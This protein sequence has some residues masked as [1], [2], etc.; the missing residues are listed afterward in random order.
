[1]KICLIIDD[2]LPHS[3][4]VGAKMMHELGVQFVK[5]GHSV[6]VITPDDT[7]SKRFEITELDGVTVCHFRSGEIKNVSKLKRA[8]NETL[9]SYN[10]WRACKDYLQ[11]NPHELIVYYS[12]SIFWGQ[13][14]NKLKKLWGASSYLI[15][16]DFFPQWVIDNGILSEHSPITS[17]FRFF[18]RL[19]YQAADTI[20]IQSPKN[21]EWFAKTSGTHKPLELLYNWASNTPILEQSNYYRKKLG[22]ENKVVYFYGGNIG[23]A[24]D[25]MNIVRLAKNMLSI[26]NIHFVLVGKGDEFD[27]VQQAIKIENLKNMTLLPAVSQAEFKAMLS[28][29]DV[30]LF[31]LHR[32]HT[33]HNFPGKLL[34][35][36][37]QSIPIL[38]SVNIDNDLQEVI[39]NA[40]AGYVTV[41]GEDDKLFENACKLQDEVL[42]KLMGQNSKKLLHDTF[43]VEV[44]VDK[45][46]DF[47]N[48]QKTKG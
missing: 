14:V 48:Q 45:I 5:M 19:S 43:S 41:N 36:M 25:M 4:K 2:Y 44:A 11:Q 27:L 13:L 38:G 8:I 28:E 21:L 7:L 29:F 9:L 39:E 18:E 42:R 37:V 3:I 16:R 46:L 34:A 40:Q 30:G 31:S 23:H 10:A 24:Q 26:E 35:Y 47:Y 17:Y 22:L 32:D 33:T 20:A 12:P 1:M 15:L 6:T